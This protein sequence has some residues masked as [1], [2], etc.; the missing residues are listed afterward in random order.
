MSRNAAVLAARPRMLLLSPF[1]CGQASSHGGAVLAWAQL[2]QLAVDFELV[3]VC[4]VGQEDVASEAKHIDGL[5]PYCTSVIRVPLQINNLHLLCALLGLLG[6]KQPEAAALCHTAAMRTALQKALVQYRPDVVWIAFPQ[7]A[8]YVA[9]CDGVPCV[10]DVQDAHSL[11]AFRH[12]Q[13]QPRWTAWR[14]WL[15]WVCWARYEAVHYARFQAVLT[16]SEQDAQILHA[17][18]PAL[19][20][21]SIGLPL[22]GAPPS[23][24][25]DAWGDVCFVGSC[26]FAPNLEGLR[27][28]LNQVWP[29]VLAKRPGA[30]F[31]IAGRHPP[32]E[33]LLQAAG[34]SV[35]VMGFV[36]KVLDFYAAHQVC[37][38][39]LMS[40]GGVKIKT[41]EALLSGTALVATRIGVEGTGIVPSKHALV[42]DDSTHF[43]QA[44]VQLLVDTELR[45]RLSAA[46]L[47]HANSFFS[48]ESW[49]QKV[50]AVLQQ[51]MGERFGG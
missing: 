20:A 40:G 37:V 44:I 30:V 31:S 13:C 32:P 51:I 43:A 49:R 23:A 17:F 47:A 25:M 12:A 11:S 22:G 36:P 5:A 28:F 2:R 50:G 7:M 26:D 15:G 3:Y 27:W 21:T 48:P 33:S 29:L 18:N 46:A 8:Q 14:A 35:R 1:L 24:G 41:V 6:L 9:Y 38:V 19:K 34:P 16:L 45:S 39:P 10:M 4:F 42:C